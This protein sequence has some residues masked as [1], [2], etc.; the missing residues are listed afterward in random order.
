MELHT[1]LWNDVDA[2]SF[3]EDDLQLIKTH[4]PELRI[5]VHKNVE[6]FLSQAQFADFVLT[7]D[8]EVAW[9]ETC[10]R[11]KT[12]FTP[13]AGNDWVHADPGNRVQLVHGTFLG[14][15][16]A[17]SLL[18][19]MLLMN[20]KMPLMILNQQSKKWDRNI[21]GSSRLLGNQTVLLI[22]LGKIGLSCAKLIQHTGAEVIGIRRNPDRKSDTGIDV[23]SM[24]ELDTLLSRADHVALLLPGN[25]GTDRFMNPD[26]LALMKPG[27]YLYNFGRGNSLNCSD[28]L[29]SLDHLGG[30]FLDVTDEEPLPA[31]SPLWDS[32]KVM[33][34]PHSSCIYHEYKSLFI[35]EVINHLKQYH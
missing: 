15:M 33:I 19:A 7:W 18:G 24:D 6:S 9:Y 16:L 10:T 31:D 27:S 32:S 30:A 2:F 26:R 13:A 22:G 35:N 34:T 28:L 3:R 11:L 12:V 5:R 8:F 29:S 14:P 23:R 1:C 17:E 21:Q 4:Y 25:A 20:H